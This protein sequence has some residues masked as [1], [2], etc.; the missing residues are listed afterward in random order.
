M[1]LP[2]VASSP[3]TIWLNKEFI[4]FL[5]IYNFRI[6]FTW[7]YWK[8]HGRLEFWKYNLNKVATKKY[9]KCFIFTLFS[10]A[11][12]RTSP[13]GFYFLFYFMQYTYAPYLIYKII[14]VIQ[15]ALKSGAP[16][17][18]F[19][20]LFLVLLGPHVLILQKHK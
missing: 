3:S 2:E 20:F 7:S 5:Q 11:Q 17:C 19:D 8:S 9:K 10:S 1:L 18:C 4:Y 15:K 16:W 14:C 13:W 12:T 6:L